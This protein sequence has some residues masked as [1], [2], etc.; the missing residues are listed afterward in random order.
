IRNNHP[1]VAEADLNS[2]SITD[3]DRCLRFLEAKGPHI[4]AEYAAVLG[5][6]KEP[7]VLA[8]TFEDMMGD[9]GKEKQEAGILAI[10]KHVEAPLESRDVPGLLA[11]HIGQETLTFSGQRSNWRRYWNDDVEQL[12]IRTGIRDV[13]RQLGYLDA[14]DGPAL[15][16]PVY[17]ESASA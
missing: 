14:A 10:A 12:F 13:N 5:W 15:R 16:E 6:R 7:G 8:M 1:I 3:A 9:N 17:R 4:L 11:K 2:P